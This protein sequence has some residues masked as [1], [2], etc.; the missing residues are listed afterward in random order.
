MPYIRNKVTDFTHEILTFN[1]VGHSICCVFLWLKESRSFV[2]EPALHCNRLLAFS[3]KILLCLSYKSNAFNISYQADSVDISQVIVFRVLASCRVINYCQRLETPAVSV[4]RVT[5][6]ISSGCIHLDMKTALR[7]LSSDIF[8]HYVLKL[9]Q[10]EIIICPE[11]EKL[12]WLWFQLRL[13]LPQYLTT[14]ALGKRDTQ[15]TWSSLF[16]LLLCASL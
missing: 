2:D 14:K 1:T 12:N 16:L 13:P 6:F 5:Q 9:I 4:F 10:C 8:K 7:R 11:F 3:L 15:K